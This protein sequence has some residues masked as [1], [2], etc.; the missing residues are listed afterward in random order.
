MAE[1]FPDLKLFVDKT[2]IL[3]SE[4]VFLDKEVYRLKKSVT[5]IQNQLCN[6]DG[7]ST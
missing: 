3:M 7:K 1:Y 2:K 5:K 6:N 4:G